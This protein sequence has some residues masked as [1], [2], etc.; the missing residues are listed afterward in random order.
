MS[1]TNSI[2]RGGA[3][4]VLLA[5]LM[6]ACAPAAAPAPAAPAAPAAQPTQA[7][8][9]PAAQATEAPAAPAAQ[10]TEA[11]AA[12]AKKAL[13]IA[14][15]TVVLDHPF[16]RSQLGTIQKLADA[17]G[18]TLHVYD[19]GNDPQKQV[20]QVDTIIAEKPDVVIFTPVDSSVGGSL[21]AKI[22]AANIPL[23]GLIRENKGAQPKVQVMVNLRAVGH[24]SGQYMLDAIKAK[25]GGEEKGVYLEL[26]GD[27]ADASVADYDG[28]FHEVMD[29]AKGIEGI[30]KPTKWD[31]GQASTATEDVLNARNDVDGI[32]L[33]SDYFIPAV[34][35]II[36]RKSAKAGDPKHIVVVGE[37]AD[38]NALD[39][40]KA[41]GMDAS[42][43]MPINDAAGMA[44]EYAVKMA[45]G[46][47][48]KPGDV[49][50]EG[51]KWSPAKLETT[52]DGNLLLN[53]A[54]WPVTVK[55]AGDQGLWG[56]QYRLDQK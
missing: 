9:A 13:V 4:L 38:S 6:A 50:K 12:P 48:I 41:G 28:G 42:I 15:S 14:Y 36:E 22:Q 44:F 55:E 3:V 5:M 56:N 37:S 17:G 39:W 40:I 27:L 51:A 19:A 53:L 10:A 21:V 29:P 11:P 34:K 47:E 54:P 23:L 16:W 43:N 45:N 1:R 35:A 2:W 20:N 26:Q 46:E 8:A 30:V 18:H 33:M 24:A 52:K 25:H 49:V 31:L 32:F 7:P